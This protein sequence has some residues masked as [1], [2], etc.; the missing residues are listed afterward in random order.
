MNLSKESLK[1]LHSRLV[2]ML[3]DAMI[4]GNDTSQIQAKINQLEL[5]LGLNESKNRRILA[6]WCAN[7]TRIW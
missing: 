1:E 5:E 3:A 2:Q 7:L 6:D 4:N